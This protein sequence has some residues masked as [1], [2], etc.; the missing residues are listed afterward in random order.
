MGPVVAR[1]GERGALLLGTL[2]GAAGFA[3]YGY[4]PTGLIYVAA[5]PV[6]TLVNF[7][8]PGLQGLMTRR[9]G[10]RHQGELQGANQGMMGIAAIF[11]P[12]IF[13]LTFAWSIHHEAS[14][15]TPGL[16]IYLAAGL[17][18]AAFLLALK[19]AHPPAAVQ[20]PPGALQADTQTP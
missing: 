7:L 17:M 18:T 11:G 3:L 5:I 16:A 20:P 9:V 8:Q 15:R 2:G 12:I 10:P 13:G 19:L 6:F 14:L 1:I 4:A